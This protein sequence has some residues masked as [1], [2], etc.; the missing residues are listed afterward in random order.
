MQETERPSETGEMPDPDIVPE[1]PPK[2]PQDEGLPDDEEGTPE[3]LSPAETTQQTLDSDGTE[4][5]LAGIR[6]LPPSL[7]PV[8]GRTHLTN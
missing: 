4:P 1:I 6:Y 3:P 8:V 5:P 7:D 2:S